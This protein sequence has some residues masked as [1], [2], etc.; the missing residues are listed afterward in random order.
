MTA[1]WKIWSE[2]PGHL[3]PRAG[4]QKPAFG[5]R[6]RTLTA[7]ISATE[8]D[9][10]NQKEIRQSTGTPLHAPKFGEL[11]SRNG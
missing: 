11:W 9:I 4:G 5:D 2:L 3:P 8:H 1:I 7:L 10:N 6:L